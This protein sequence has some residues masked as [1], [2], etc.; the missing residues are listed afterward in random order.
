MIDLAGHDKNKFIIDIKDNNLFVAIGCSWTRAWGAVDNCLDFRSPLYKDDLNFFNNLSYVGKVCNF[1]NYTSKIVMAIPGSN[2]DMQ[3]RLLFELLQKNRHKFDKIFV[4]WGITSHLRWELYS[5]QINAPSM[6]MLGSNVPPGKEEERK[7][8]LM[9]HWNNDFEM[10]RLSH[11]I[12]ATSCYLKN[13]DVGH[14]FFPVFESYNNFNMNLNNVDKSNYFGINNKTNDMLHLWCNSEGLTI[15][16][17]VLSNPY[18]DDDRSKLNLLVSKGYLSKAYAH[19]TLVGHN[20]IALRLI[21]HL[22]A[23]NESNTI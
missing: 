15:D 13:L 10:E 17:C 19:P 4:L 7:W 5:N 6:F 23:H 3:T 22:K 12:V 18:S 14:L 9:R 21:D 16:N 11:K 8:F 2:N 20:D 1:L